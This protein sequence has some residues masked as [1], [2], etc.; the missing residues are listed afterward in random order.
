[1]TMSGGLGVGGA[2]NAF[3]FS[4]T[5]GRIQGS[6][7]QGVNYPSPFFDVAHTYLP[8]TVKQMFRWCRYYFLTNPLINAVV[9]K[10]SEYPITDIILTHDD[11]ITR[12]RWMDF[13]QDHLQYRSFQV[14]VGLDYFTYGN[15]FIS[16]GYGFQK[17]LQ[18][19]TCSW[20]EVANR[21]R[22]HWVFTNYCFRLACPA[23]HTT[24]DALVKD[25]YLKNPSGVKLIRWNAEDMEILY[26]DL[27][28]EYTYF[29][30]IP[31]VIRNEPR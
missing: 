21:C 8:V 27:T 2:G 12:D 18:C 29:Y 7:V 20:R 17:Y 1:M 10:M 30:T 28:G 16:V 15:A 5:R 25:L 6:P 31:A 22:N 24:G 26:N 11:E 19:P 4:Q 23:C 14:E 3:R 9:A 13:L